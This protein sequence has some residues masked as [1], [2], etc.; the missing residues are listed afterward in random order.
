MRPSDHPLEV[1]DFSS[2]EQLRKAFVHDFQY[3][4]H[5]QSDHYT[6]VA[7]FVALAIKQASASAAIPSEVPV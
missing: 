4:F 6:V 7:H 1:T 2:I 3:R 5:K